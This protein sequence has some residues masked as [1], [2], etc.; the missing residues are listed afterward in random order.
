MDRFGKFLTIV[1]LCA[2]VV[3]VA[4][5]WAIDTVT[6]SN[7]ERGVRV[8][9]ENSISQQEADTAK[10]LS[11]AGKLDAE[12]KEI[13]GRAALNTL[14]GYIQ[15]VLCLVAFVALVAFGGRFVRRGP[16]SVSIE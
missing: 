6:Q 7:L 4:G 8:V 16:P 14:F 3:V 11:E 9:R 13:N 1:S 2:M 5:V 10:T 12:A 15:V